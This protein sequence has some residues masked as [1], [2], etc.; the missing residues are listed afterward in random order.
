MDIKQLKQSVYQTMKK[1]LLDCH[2]VINACSQ[3]SF[4][5]ISGEYLSQLNQLGLKDIITKEQ[6]TE[7]AM[8][9]REDVLKEKVRRELSPIEGKTWYPLGILLHISADNVDGLPAFSVI[10]GLLSGNINILKLPWKEN[11]ISTFLLK[12]LIAIEPGLKEYIY[13]FRF[14]SGKKWI[15]SQLAE[16]AD[17]ICVWGDDETILSMRQMAG[18]NT[19]LIEWGNKI[20]FAY[21]TKG[22]RNDRQLYSLARHMIETNQLLCSS[23]QGIYLDTDKE[24]EGKEFSRY[25]LTILE[26]ARQDLGEMDLGRRALQ[27]L[28]VY[29]HGLETAQTEEELYEGKGVSVAWN[30]DNRLNPSLMFGNCWVKSLP[31]EHIIDVLKPYKGYLQ[32][33]CLLCKE[34]E[35]D[36]LSMALYRAGIVRVR[37]GMGIHRSVTDEAHDGQLALA[38]YSR[39]VDGF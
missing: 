20:S 1:P 37:D 5:L 18:A 28:R 19:R 9:L 30:S 35:K 38:R 39:L 27:K 6:M 26:E 24:S 13:I 29:S 10:E 17:G 32:T 14:P 15:I 34:D 22:G 23:C 8:M 36:E 3:L 25:F 11:G 2:M 16:I 33:A 31:K 21:I 4:K 7:A 12:E